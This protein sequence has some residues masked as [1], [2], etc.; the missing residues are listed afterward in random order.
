MAYRDLL[1]HLD[2]AATSATRT[3]VACELA[4]TQDAHLVGVYVEP[5]LPSMLFPGDLP[6]AELIESELEE[7]ARRRDASRAM[8]EQAA[9]AAGIRH[10][11]RHLDDGRV[12]ALA[13]SARYSDLVIAGR[14]ED[15]DPDSVV[16][17]AQDVAL[18]GG[19]PVLVVPRTFTGT[20]G[21][22]VLVAWNASRE[23]VRAVHDAMPLLARATQVRVLTVDAG[24]G[25]D[26]HGPVPGADICAHL[27]RHDVRA[28]A[29]EAQT[30]GERVP[31][32]IIERA[33]EF[34]ADLV[35]MGVYGHSRLR[36]LVLG[37]ASR[38]LLRHSE[39]PLLIS[40]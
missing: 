36:E 23:A 15:G 25:E 29:L 28:E 14:R 40:H 1:V 22:S 17:V 11:W 5:P 33:R 21:R 20:P 32:L 39:V 2:D 7:A 4:R 24:V 27:A 18:G 6:A 31:E 37:G 9:Q 12:H 10:E 26:G 3:T 38:Y 35:V 19:R 16:E 8:F 30:H 34:G 13:V